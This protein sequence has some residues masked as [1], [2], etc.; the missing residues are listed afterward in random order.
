MVL[1]SHHPNFRFSRRTCSR[2]NFLKKKLAGNY[3]TG[4][5]IHAFGCSH[6]VIVAFAFLL[7]G[8]TGVVDA[9]GMMATSE[10]VPAH[11]ACKLERALPAVATAAVTV[12]A[13]AAAAITAAA[14]ATIPTGVGVEVLFR[15]SCDC[16]Q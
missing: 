7:A 11:V 5:S 10:A 3:S 14:V 12:A 6:T 9:N 15:C 8:C 13:V 1:P 16:L 2:E 4:P